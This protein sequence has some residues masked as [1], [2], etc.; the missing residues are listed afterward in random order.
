MICFCI[1]ICCFGC[2]KH[3]ENVDTKS[4]HSQYNEKQEKVIDSSLKGSRN[5]NY[6][7]LDK[8]RWMELRFEEEGYKSVPDDDK[9]KQKIMELM[10]Q[11]AKLLGY[12][13]DDIY[14]IVL[15]DKY[16]SKVNR[17]DYWFSYICLKEMAVD[18]DCKVWIIQVDDEYMIMKLVRSPYQ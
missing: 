11:L 2:R 7:N 15:K 1:I 5:K 12:S 9:H 8:K 13:L 14:I 17:M 10:K 16:E 6:D 4:N 3:K 18:G